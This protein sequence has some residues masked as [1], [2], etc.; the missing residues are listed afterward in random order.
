MI[1][2]RNAIGGLKVKININ[3]PECRGRSQKDGTSQR[4]GHEDQFNGLSI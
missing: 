3:F 2:E 1:G 4:E